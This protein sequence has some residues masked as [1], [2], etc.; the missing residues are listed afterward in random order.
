MQTKF[1]LSK[2][3]YVCA[4]AESYECDHDPVDFKSHHSGK[5]ILINVLNIITI[6]LIL[7]EEVVKL[8]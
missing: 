8:T 6:F 7:S 4:V 1:L 3:N 2:L 5:R